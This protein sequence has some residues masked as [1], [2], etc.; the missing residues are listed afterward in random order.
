MLYVQGGGRCTK[1]IVQR[2]VQGELD[3]EGGEEKEE[4][5][6]W[7]LP[8]HSMPTCLQSSLTAFCILSHQDSSDYTDRSVLHMFIAIA[9]KADQFLTFSEI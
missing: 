4:N 8:F 7:L 5:Q 1:K 3:K 2:E 6:V 9:Y